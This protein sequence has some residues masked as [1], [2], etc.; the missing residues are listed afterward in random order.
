MMLSLGRRGRNLANTTAA[1]WGMARDPQRRVAARF[2]ADPNLAGSF[3]NRWLLVRQ[4]YVASRRLI[5]PHTTEEIL[6]FVREI[7]MLPADRHGCIVEAGSYKGSSAAKFSLA[8]RLAGRRLVIC[9]SF[10]GLPSDENHGLSIDNRPVVFRAGEFA[11]PLD[12]VK[13]NIARYGAL[14]VCDFVA[15]WFATSLAG[16]N[17]PIAAVYLDVDLA[18]S[19]RECLRHFYRWMAPGSAL[20]S[21]DGHLALVL[22]VF[23][24]RAFWRSEF[25]IEPP[26][27]EG[28]WRKKL[29]KLTKGQA[30]HRV[31]E[32]EHSSFSRRVGEYY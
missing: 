32:E 3:A 19:T 28:A 21:Q 11:G 24:D 18:A 12:E 7:L 14:E 31:K 16:W 17:R 25:G 8:A 20:Y 30:E 6:A 29:I 1:L 2:L 22:A 27:V 5:S 10:Q 9:D 26:L 23:E 4:H 13:A 15:G